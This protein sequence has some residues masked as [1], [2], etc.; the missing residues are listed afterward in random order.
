MS[1]LYSLTV[2]QI[3]TLMHE[4]LQAALDLCLHI[5]ASYNQD[6]QD[7]AADSDRLYETQIQL[8]A[9]AYIAGS[10]ICSWSAILRY[11]TDETR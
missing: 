1:S 7:L 3:H 6:S 5:Q 11:H 2:L 4:P 8:G 9:A 10:A